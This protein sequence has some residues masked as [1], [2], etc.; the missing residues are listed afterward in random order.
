MCD[1][2]VGAT[3]LGLVERGMD[4]VVRPALMSPLSET[5]CISCGMCVT[6]CPTGAITE[7]MM[8][9]KQVPLKEEATHTI[10]SQCSVG[11]KTKLMTSGNLLV[12]NLPV[13][14]DALL[15]VNGRFGFGEIAQ[16][17]R[18]KSPLINGAEATYEEAVVF[19]NK[20]LQGLQTQYGAD[21]IA[22]AVSGRYT[23]EEAQLIVDYAKHVLR[24]QNIFSF[25]HTKGGLDVSTATFDEME[26]TELIV[27]VSPASI[28][29]NHAVAAMRMK[30]AVNR[31]AK[32]LLVSSEDSLLD[33]VAS[34]RVDSI[35]SEKAREVISKARK[36]VFVFEKNAVSVQESDAIVRIAEEYGH[37]GDATRS[38]IIQLLPRANSQGLINLG[39]KPREDYVNAINS[40]KIRGLFIF[41]GDAVDVDLA[42]LD[43]LAVQDLHMT[44]TAA[45]AQVV[46]PASSFAELNGSYTSADGKVQKLQKAVECQVRWDNERLVKALSC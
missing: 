43:F 46:F 1:E 40:G 44:D 32:L 12:R 14:E 36:V 24:T 9:A 30:R 27:A 25:E 41:G 7:R 4:T 26:N 17:P 18:L 35:E 19:A 37:G 5:D 23:N 3:A 42:A 33:S 21:S 11:C 8:I 28:I 34:L 31:G 45:K 2:V 22:V 13:D 16:K 10:C 39:I 6:V 15:C 20:K 29:S 38:G